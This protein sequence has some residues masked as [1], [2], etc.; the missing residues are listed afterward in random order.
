LLDP[1]A[2]FGELDVDDVTQLLGSVLGNAHDTGLAVGG[3]VDPFVVLCV[4][5]DEGC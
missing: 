5:A 1:F 2:L 4:S 3:E